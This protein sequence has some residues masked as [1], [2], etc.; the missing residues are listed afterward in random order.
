MDPARQAATKR[1]MTSLNSGTEATHH[2]GVA[3]LLMNI[4]EDKLTEI[5]EAIFKGHK[6]QAI[7]L[8]RE[9]TNAGLAEAKNG[10]EKLETELRAAAPER[11]STQASG[12]G[13]LTAVVTLCAIVIAALLWMIGKAG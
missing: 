12:R 11:Y 4:P 10:V 1:E 6:I 3:N 9:A 8:Y 5:K 2:G 13:C 7:K